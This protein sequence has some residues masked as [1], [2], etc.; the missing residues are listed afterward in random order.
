MTKLDFK[1]KKLLVCSKKIKHLNWML[2]KAM[3]ERQE[4]DSYDYEKSLLKE[5]NYY[6]EV[7]DKI[8]VSL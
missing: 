5:Y 1:Q 4:K 3:L 8:E 2:G 7:Q 6:K